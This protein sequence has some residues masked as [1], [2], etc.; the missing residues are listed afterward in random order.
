MKKSFIAVAGQACGQLAMLAVT[1]VLTR[2]L[3]PEQLGIYQIAVA[4]ALVLQPIA[5]LRYEY[6]IPTAR[7]T[8]RLTLYVKVAR[9]ITWSSSVVILL[10]AA[11]VAVIGAPD[12]QM[13][14]MIAAL[15]FVYASMAIDNALLVRMRS[16]KRLGLRNLLSGVITA[17][18]H[19]AVA[20]L[21]PE[22]LLLAASI[23]VSR[24]F[25]VIV[26]RA[27]RTDAYRELGEDQLEG[28]YGGK[29]MVSTVASSVLSTLTIQGLTLSSAAFLGPRAAGIISTSQRITA[30]PASLIGQGIAQVAQANAAASINARDGSL[31]RAMKRVMVKVAPVSALLATAMV[32]LGPLLAV[33]VLGAG[34]DSAGMVIAILAPVVAFQLVTS[35]LSPVLVMIG[36]ERI[37]LRQSLI[38]SIVSLGVTA[39]AAGVSG[40][41][42]LTVAVFSAS[43]CA[44]Y[45]TQ[46]MAIFAA[47]RAHDNLE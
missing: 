10:V 33:P 44:L 7:S 32:I 16:L 3:G 31:T 43:M 41:M 14:V 39:L 2:A 22:P 30:T 11:G 12:A 34:W 23:T 5:S 37:L 45:V 6:A 25:A 29:R 40:S 27:P 8:E 13:L 1:P 24:L 9:L 4:I 38:R 17:A 46:L 21:Y 36:Q 42:L 35:P 26:T 19:L 18:L 47:L 28:A 20:L 15:V